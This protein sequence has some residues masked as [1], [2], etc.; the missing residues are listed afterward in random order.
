VC[1][2]LIPP[3]AQNRIQGWHP[4]FIGP[5]VFI[6]EDL[7]IVNPAPPDIQRVRGPSISQASGES[8]GTHHAVAYL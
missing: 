2:R 3:M 5:G 4:G 1:L 7:A 8:L 6:S